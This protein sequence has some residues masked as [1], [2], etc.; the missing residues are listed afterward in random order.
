MSAVTANAGKD[1]QYYARALRAPRIGDGY[2]HLADTARD[3]GWTHEEYLAAV[4]SREVA[5]REAS[6]AA[7]RVKAAKFPGHKTLEEFN[8]DHQPAADRSLIAHLGTGLFLEEAKNVVLLGPPGTGKTHL[9][10][11]IATRAAHS[12][13]RVLFDSATGWVARLAQAHNRGQLAAEL[14]KL[15]RY[16]LLIIDEV[17]YIPFDQDSANLFF[18]LVSSRYER[19]SLILT[20]NLAFSRWADVFGDATIASAMIDRIIHHA[21]VI[22]LTGNS[23]RLQGRLK[24]QTMAQ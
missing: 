1:V 19:A 23:Y 13:H 16:K 5:E 4:L 3:A 17:G 20:S 22:N 8:F 2:R 24:P 11:G 18:Q 14:A 21:E 10:V 15:R 12:G 7:L 6:G 9:A